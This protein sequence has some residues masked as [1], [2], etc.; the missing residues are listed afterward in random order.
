M[1]RMLKEAAFYKCE[2]GATQVQLVRTIDLD[3]HGYQ[4]HRVVGAL[5]Q[6]GTTIAPESCVFCGGWLQRQLTGP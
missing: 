3:D 1:S 5:K 6:E 4:D 2:C